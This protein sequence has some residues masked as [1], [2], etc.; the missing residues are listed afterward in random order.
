M[1]I[2]ALS[3]SLEESDKLY[4][5]KLIREKKGELVWSSHGF[6]VPDHIEQYNKQLIIELKWC[7]DPSIEKA[8][9]IAKR[10]GMPYLGDV[11]YNVLYIPFEESHL[12]Y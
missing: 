3:T 5:F 1:D 8:K 6:N 7:D 11:P 9:E 4:L 12:E 10:S 2:Y